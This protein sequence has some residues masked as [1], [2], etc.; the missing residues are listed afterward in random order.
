MYYSNQRVEVHRSARQ[1]SIRDDD[2][3]H[4]TDHPV[5][6]VDVDDDADPDPPKLLVIGPDTAGNL[7]EVV[8]LILAQERQLAIHA[9]PLRRAY[10][11][12]LSKGG[13]ADA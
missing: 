10:Y 13:D 11:D 9:M 1:H 12:L 6:V 8:V 2:I 7:L 5:V 4:A 3:R